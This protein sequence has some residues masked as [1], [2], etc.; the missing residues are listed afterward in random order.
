MSKKGEHKGISFGT[1]IWVIIALVDLCALTYF[2]GILPVISIEKGIDQISAGNYN[3]GFE[4]IFKG[5]LPW[6]LIIFL[7]C[8]SF[9]TVFRSVCPLDIAV[10]VLKKL[11]QP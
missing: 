8:L 4:T 7:F 5:L 2:F 1:I 3:E 9:I 6:L 11:S 10:I